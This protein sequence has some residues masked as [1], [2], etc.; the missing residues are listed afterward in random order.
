MKVLNASQSKELDKTAIEDFG[1]PGIDLM[2]EAGR[3]IASEILKRYNPDRVLIVCG[4]GNNAG[5]GFVVAQH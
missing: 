4:K 5:D 2:N 1:I 3:A